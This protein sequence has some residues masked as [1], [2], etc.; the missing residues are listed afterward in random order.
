MKKLELS[1]KEPGRPAATEAAPY[2]FRY[3]D[4]APAGDV[5]Q[6]LS[7]QLKEMLAWCANIS[8]EKSQFRYAP[9]KWSIRQVLN[10]LTDSERVFACRAL[11]FARGFDTAL[12]SFDQNIAA[13][14]AEADNISWAAHVDEFRSVRVASISLFMNL[15][16]AAWMRGG[17]A[18]GNYVSVRALAYI[19]AGHMRH[20]LT[21]LQ[22]QYQSGL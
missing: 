7:T 3:I 11:W 12:P 22:Q 9:D 5:L 17:I 15:P 4:R 2:Y 6:L 14:G 10:H 1:A 13:A 18:S 19:I 20:H 16:A 8:E 21:I